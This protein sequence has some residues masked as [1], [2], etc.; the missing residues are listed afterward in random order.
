MKKYEYIKV[1]DVEISYTNLKQV[2]H[3]LII[4]IVG[5]TTREELEQ[6]DFSVIDFYNRGGA[7]MG[8]Y[9]GYSTIY[10]YV[11]TVLRLS[12]YDSTHVEPLPYEYITIDDGD[13]IDIESLTN[14]GNILSITLVTAAS[15]IENSM[16]NK[17]ISHYSR[18][19]SLINE[20]TGFDGV[21]RVNGATI[22]LSNDGSIYDPAE[23]AALN[24][25]KA[26]QEKIDELSQICAREITDGVDVTVKND[27]KHFHFTAEDQ[28]N[29]K[30]AFDLAMATEM[31]VPY[32]AD[33]ENCDLYTPEE[34]VT[35]YVAEQTNLTH[36]QT[37]F[38]QL[39]QYVMSLDDIDDVEDVN[40]GQELTG[41][42]LA[43]YNTM[44]TQTQAIISKMLGL[45]E[46]ENAETVENI[47]PEADGN[48]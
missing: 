11:G 48:I 44:M 7:K 4:A 32:H 36:H 30:A 46:G 1:G 40:Y 39:K 22:Q 23:E 24:L 29:M 41:Q 20:Y 13:P 37:Y 47:D 6:L 5:P 45:S 31:S 8:T 35:V 2:D 28:Q 42:Y 33:N 19:N 15:G 25:A 34:I 9:E 21:Y 10:D 18:E 38:N 43:T 26:K 14:N 12:N 27:T 3:F 17:K 16:I